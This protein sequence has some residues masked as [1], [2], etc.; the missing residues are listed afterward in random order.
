MEL[1]SSI[2]S[3]G[4]RLE[5]FDL[6]LD[7]ASTRFSLA[8]SS[9][10]SFAFCD[11]PCPRENRRIRHRSHTRTCAVSCRVDTKLDAGLLQS[12]PPP[13]LESHE[14]SSLTLEYRRECG[15][16]SVLQSLTK[17]S[18][19]GGGSVDSGYVECEHMLRLEDGPE[20]LKARTEWRPK[21]ANILGSLGQLSVAESA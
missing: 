18:G 2:G 8:L 4:W 17:V 6:R 9:F 11:E 19:G 16:D 10:I 20:I 3:T 5:V 15:R 13:I 21:Y 7:G 14:L 12:A 1:R